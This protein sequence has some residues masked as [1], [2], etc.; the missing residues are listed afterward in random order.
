MD[1][2]AL[3]I[4]GGTGFVGHHLTA[5]LVDAGYH[6]KI[7]TRDPSRH[8][9][10]LVLPT[11]KLVRA[12]VHDPATLKRELDGVGAVINLVG[13]LNERGHNG[14][15]FEHAHVELT[16]K[17]LDACR[18]NHVPRLLQ[19]SA[20]G[21]DP[22]S[23]SHYQRTRGEA[24]QLLPLTPDGMPA[25]TVFQPSIIF[26]PQDTFINRF[27]RL[28]KLSPGVLLLPCP[29]ARVAPV[30]VGNV[31]E[32]FVRSLT[33]RDTIGRR[34]ALYGPDVYTMRNIVRYTARMIGVHR[35]I[36]GLPDWASRLMANVME[37]VPGK[38]FSRDNYLS[39]KAGGVE[40]ESGLAA[41]DIA[42]ASLEAEIPNYLA[43]DNQRGR[44][45]RYRAVAGR[46]KESPP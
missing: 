11:I 33:R 26:G 35:A 16:R 7:L 17:V 34:Y 28:L 31:A 12:D 3:C 43:A 8:R 14:S 37:Y 15:G 18:T 46:F 6:V 29:G 25:T 32:A 38:P 4:L 24:E 22:S 2:R 41:L 5:R 42:P 44:Y 45:N 39:F 23:A 27:A 40:A 20:L 21:A 1:Y 13:I 19:M 9:D 36:I 10:L 30:Y